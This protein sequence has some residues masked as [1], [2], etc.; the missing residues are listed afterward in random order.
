[1]R[2]SRRDAIRTTTVS[3]PSRAAQSGSPP[4]AFRAETTAKPRETP[5]CVSGMLAA[6]AAAVKLLTPGTTSQA[7]PAAAQASISS[8]P[9]PKTAGSPPL[10]RTT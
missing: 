4:S 10:S 1:M 9:R 7:T 8:P 6:A 2:S 3:A 5:R